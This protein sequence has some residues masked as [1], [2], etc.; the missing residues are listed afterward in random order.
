MEIYKILSNI[1]VERGLTIPDV[2][3]A[4]NLSDSTVRG[5][6][7]RKQ[8]SVALEVAFKL[9][10]GLCVSLER[11]NG[12]MELEQNSSF[13]ERLKLALGSV[14]STELASQ[15]GLSKQA[16]STYLTSTRTPKLPVVK[17]IAV[18]L[19]VSEMWLMGY[20]VPKERREDTP[21]QDSIPSLSSLE[22]DIIKKYRSLD[23]RGQKAVLDTLNR[24]CE[25]VDAAPA[26]SGISQEIIADA[27]HTIDDLAGVT[28]TINQLQSTSKK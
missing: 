14:T 11:L 28:S 17:S 15:I 4:C 24:E 19:D 18:A 13:A 8:K 27:I 21:L 12:E 10:S 5:I 23:L 20:D 16:I 22:I 26:S 1:M 9:S 7:V 3:R 25:F 6:V 2:A